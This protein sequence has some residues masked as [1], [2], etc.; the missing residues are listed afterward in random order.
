MID[1]W[2]GFQFEEGQGGVLF[3]P[4]FTENDLREAVAQQAAPSIG[5]SIGELAISPFIF[6]IVIA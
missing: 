1:P 5:I 3:K 6:S 2:P 4:M